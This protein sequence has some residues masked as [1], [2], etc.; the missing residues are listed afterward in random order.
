[1]LRL[2]QQRPLTTTLAYPLHGQALVATILIV[3]AAGAAYCHGYERLLTG[4]HEWPGSFLWS[5]VAVL[6]W[7]ALFEWSK[8]PAGERLGSR[9]WQLLLALL[10]TAAASILLQAAADAIAGN[11]SRSVALNLL[12]RLPPL[13][14]GVVLILWAR[15]VRSAR[16]MAARNEADAGPANLVQIAGS[17]D[18]I[19][20]AD[21]YIEL[22]IGHRTLIRRMTLSAAE[23]E[24][25]SCDFVRIHRRYLVNRRR[26]EAVAGTNGDRRVR[27]A[28]SELPIGRRYASRLDA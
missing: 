21:N 23:R 12:R 13:G 27:I 4:A 19:A 6:P 16:A 5:A 22:Q 20:A 18:W 1:M 2:R 10:A 3:W 14:A 28:G 8:T 24:L 7:L 25:A 26:I 15:S 11:A 17:I 9:P